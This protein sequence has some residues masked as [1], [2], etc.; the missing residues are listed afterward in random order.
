MSVSLRPVAVPRMQTV[1][2][3]S[4]AVVI[5]AVCWRQAHCGLPASIPG[6]NETN[7]D[8]NLSRRGDPSWWRMCKP[9]CSFRRIDH[10]VAIPVTRICIAPAMHYLCLRL[11]PD[12]RRQPA[13]DR[14]CAY[15]QQLAYYCR[16]ALMH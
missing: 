13:P 2:A 4:H 5:R 3:S 9:N 8:A 12:K 10:V 16:E 1:R 14:G 15:V 11:Q 6:R 7:C